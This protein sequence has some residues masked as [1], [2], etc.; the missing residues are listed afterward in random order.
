M[1]LPKE[2]IQGNPL[3]PPVLIE[4]KRLIIRNIS[5]YELDSFLQY[6]NEPEVARYQSWEPNLDKAYGYN[7]I[8]NLVSKKIGDPGNWNQIVWKLK[9][10]GQH[11]GD[12][13]LFVTEDAKQAEIGYTLATKFQKQGFAT[14]AVSAIIDFAFNK[15]NLHRIYASCDCK[16]YSSFKLLEK[17][18]FRREG[19]YIENIFFKGAWGDEFFY[20]L[21]KKEWNYKK[22]I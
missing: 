9:E 12:C 4:T 22:H 6:R 10:T 7:F 19:H 21:L 16:N 5:L 20:A 15:L 8:N 17:L 1:N 14:E 13:A 3:E 11:I 2:Q 18:G